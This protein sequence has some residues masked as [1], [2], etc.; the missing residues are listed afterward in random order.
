VRENEESRPSRA[1]VSAAKG[2]LFLCSQFTLFLH[3]LFQ[4]A[5]LIVIYFKHAVQ[6][7]VVLI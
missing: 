4:V 2:I 5:S 1:F 6:N 3:R 7:V